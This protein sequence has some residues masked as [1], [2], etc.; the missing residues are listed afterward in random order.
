[1]HFAKDRAGPPVKMT[2]EAE[3]KVI[4]SMALLKH[5]DPE[6]PADDSKPAGS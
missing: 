6:K 1:M 4:S 3:G 2:R 5:G